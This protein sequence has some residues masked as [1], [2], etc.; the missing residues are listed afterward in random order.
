MST[1]TQA[2]GWVSDLSQNGHGSYSYTYSLSLSLTL[3]L[4]YESSH[5]RWVGP[6]EDN[7][8][9]SKQEASCTT[10]AQHEHTS[11]VTIRT[12]ATYHDW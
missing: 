11:G 10:S 7:A 12:L 9:V 1:E 6:N 2:R 5:T 8:D 3:S 4:S